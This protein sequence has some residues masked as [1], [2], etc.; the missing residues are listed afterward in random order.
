MDALKKQCTTLL[1]D[2]CFYPKKCSINFFEFL[3]KTAGIN[4]INK[5]SCDRKKLQIFLNSR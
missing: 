2:N 4:K 1:D 3:E 5:I